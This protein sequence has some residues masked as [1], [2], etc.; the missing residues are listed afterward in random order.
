MQDDERRKVA[1]ACGA[2][3]FVGWRASLSSRHPFG[4]YVQHGSEAKASPVSA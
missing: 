4:R 3:A 2:Q 1:C